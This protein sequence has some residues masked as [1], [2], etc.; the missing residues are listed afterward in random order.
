MEIEYRDMNG[1]RLRPLNPDRRP[2]SFIIALRENTLFIG[3]SDLQQSLAGKVFMG[4]GAVAATEH[5]L[6]SMAAC[7]AMQDGGNAFDGAAAASFALAVTQPHLNGL[8]GDFFG[9]F[10]RASEGKVYC[11]NSSGWA[12]ASRTAESLRA[13][14]HETVPRFGHA[15]VVIPGYVMGV[16]EMQRRFGLLEFSRSLDDATRLASEGFPVGEGLVRSLTAARGS[17]SKEAMQTFEI[18]GK[19]PRVGSILRQERL[20]ETL[21]EIAR[22][23]PEGFYR[24][25]PAR[26]IRE[27]MSRAGQP[28]DEEDLASFMP[29]WCD[30]LVAPYRG[31]EVC[32]V[33][34]NSMGA[35][36]LLILKLL[37]EA[38]SGSFGP[39]SAERVSA[40]VEAAKTAYA[41]RDRELGDPRFVRFGLDE[42]L[43]SK[44]G[45][46]TQRK[47]DE[48]DTTY[49]AVADREGNV[50]SCIQSIFHHFGSRVFLE[51]CGFF[52]NNRGAAFT[53]E[54]PNRVE[55]RKRPLHTLS[56]LILLRNG[57]PA[58]ATGCSGGEYRPQQHAL[59]VTNLVDY[60]MNL[61]Q[62]IDF[63]RFLWDGQADVRIEAGYTGLDGLTLKHEVIRYPGNTGVAQG[64][65]SMDECAKGVCDVR[66]EGLPAGF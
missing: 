20:A 42:F 52:L 27:T 39:G 60:S 49:F 24:G 56:S 10:Y 29:E 33:P 15:S 64:I 23:G 18:D 6:A 38:D 4:R 57:R 65:E 36:T 35:T 34:P 31:I 13:S 28:V 41:A 51:D 5:P 26:S 21:R 17:L 45:A 66:G 44:A 22:D 16:Y 46:G 48:A 25:R 54:G 55:P 11:L 37:E 30:P 47:I 53:M 58:F 62:A 40:T 50:L 12:P 1:S 63:P 9:L 19:A 59:L 2:E 32:E 8:G 43:K 14:G 3:P 61:E 7:R